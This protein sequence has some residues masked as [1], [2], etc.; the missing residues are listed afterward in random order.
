M[1]KYKIGV[2]ERGD[3][4][5]DLSWVDKLHAVDGAIVITKQI[6][7][8]FAEAVLEHKDKL[9]LHATVT[10][11]GH[12]IL[13]PNVPYPIDELHVVEDLC[14]QG[15]PKE[16]VVVRVDPIIP[17]EKGLDKASQIIY[18]SMEA[19]FARYRVSLIDMYPHVRERFAL[20]GLSCPYG[21]NG[22]S[23]SNEQRKN[24][25]A[26]LLD[27]Q[28]YW[29]SHKMTAWDDSLRI[30]SCAEP[31]L[32]NVIPCGCVS[33]YDLRL[34]GLD[35]SDIDCLGPQRHGC[36]CYSGKTELLSTKS[37]CQHNC[38]YCYW[39]R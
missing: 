37:P 38:L 6:T 25:S 32:K 22:F 17:T 33:G 3:A 13:E 15:F 21:S 36:M 20:K 24:T 27:C 8:A 1:S 7:P 14:R 16:K 2:T 12:S 19:G 29:N 4:G 39:K 18:T 30:E 9:I 23:P 28:E 31:G 10:G 5:L 34:L 35:D 11:Y 26:M